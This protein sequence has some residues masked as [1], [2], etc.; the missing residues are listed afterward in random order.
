MRNRGASYWAAA[1]VIFCVAN[2][3]HAV[4][5]QFSYN[6]THSGTWTLLT[7]DDATKRV[8]GYGIAV[9]TFFTGT[10][11]IATPEEIH[12]DL[13]LP[14]DKIRIGNFTL[15]RKERWM[16]SLGSPGRTDLKDRCFSGPPASVLELWPLLRLHWQ[17]EAS[18]TATPSQHARISSFLLNASTETLSPEKE[19]ALKPGDLFR[20]CKDC[21]V[22]EVVPAG[23]FTMGSPAREPGRFS[24]EG[25]Q[26]TVTIARQ[27]AVGRDEVTFLQWDACVA[28][29]GCNGY[30]PDDSGWGRG[31]RPV[32]NVSWDDANA[33]V[34]WLS[35]KTGKSYR[36]LSESKY[37]YATRARTTG[38]YPW[39]WGGDVKFKGQARANCNGCG[40]Q[41]DGKQTATV[42]AFRAND[43][44]LD[45]MLGN[46][47][48]WT[49]DCYHDNYDGA[50]TDGTAWTS[51]DCSRHVLRGG[52]W[53]VS[54]R[55]VRS[56][57]REG[58]SSSVRLNSVGF[59]VGQML[60]AP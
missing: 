7:F 33:Y 25:P 52:A 19:R 3:S 39:G 42:S 35:K 2:A 32:I 14:F 6:C 53:N 30:R 10:I 48:E 45:A 59:R 20:E 37:E 28:D 31:L 60:L 29:G 44:G 50:P 5:D 21:P 26:H 1:L 47:W 22:M 16:T 24:N 38:A 4:A 43:F 49:Q 40:S 17:E 27:F 55:A 15:N 54:P 56:A 11:S 58:N 51:G 36:L 13:V 18:A 9:N 46:V 8:I 34:A 12:F 41:W 23:N 57:V